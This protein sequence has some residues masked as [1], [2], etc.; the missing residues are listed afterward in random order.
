MTSGQRQAERELTRLVAASGGALDLIG[1]PFFEKSLLVATVGLQIGVIESREDGLDLREREEF[2]LF[3]PPDFPFDR[4]SLC[5]AHARFAGFPHVT[6]THRL[7]LY[8]SSIEWNPSDGLYGF[9]SRL[10]AWIAKAAINDMDPIEGPLEPPHHDTDFT[11][12]PFVVRAD[13]PCAA[14]E[15]WVGLGLT[16]KHENRTELIGWNDLSGGWPQHERVAFAVVL[17]RALP[18]EFP[19]KGAEL[20]RAMQEAGMERE[21][22]VK[23]LAIAALLTPK[24]E[25]IHLVLGLP[26]RRAKD[27]SQRL[28]IAVW[29]TEPDQADSLRNVL[30][31]DADTETIRGLRDKIGDS[32]ARIFELG[33]IKWCQVLEN[34]PEIVVRRDSG[35]PA[36]WFA[37][38]NILVLGCGA[39]G[40]WAAEIMARAGPSDL[41]LVDTA[42]VKPGILARQNF[43]LQDIGSNKAQALAGRLTAIVQG[44]TVAPH[45]REAHA[46]LMEDKGR[47]RDYDLVLDCTA[48]SNFQMKLERDWKEFSGQ[49]PPVVSL[50]IDS[51][52]KHS[53]CVAIPR[54][55][56]GGIWHAY[57]SLK[58]SLCV[59]G[60]H[61]SLIRA[62]YSSSA[63]EKLFQPEPGCSDPTFVGSAADVLALTSDAVNMAV[64]SIQEPEFGVGIALSAPVAS[65]NSRACDLVRLPEFLDTA[66]GKYRVRIATSVF[67][68]ARGW[69][70]QNNRRRSSDHETGGLLW[71][72]WDDA[73]EVIWIYDLSGPPPDSKHSPAHFL[74][75][76]GGTTEEHNRR[77]AGTHGVCGFVGHWHT[78]PDFP[79]EQSATDMRTMAGLVASIGQNQKRSIM[80]I[81]G[82]TLGAATAGIYAYESAS[83]AG[84]GELVSVGIAQIAL[85]KPVL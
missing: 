75:G 50:V 17:P 3:V 78:H 49:T 4:P 5:V 48:S 53:L 55:A 46:F 67:N 35:T 72:F 33:K 83:F 7:C 29:T 58:K 31:E 42:V 65:G 41:H 56:A 70:K 18:M 22:I 79:S 51:Q 37:G 84:N 77:K 14:G 73:I 26:M 12:K 16:V 27:G 10:K 62:F 61:A 6:W 1:E 20:F 23:N 34:R 59:E 80:L 30:P 40:S 63:T 39:L 21:Q 52:A 47:F 25:P 71:G 69:V 85:T 54:G 9:F 60:N 74:C 38:K 68:Q 24:D 13:A 11:Q 19:T 45:A 15:S 66:V 28:H 44:C 81:F 32:L 64:N 8:Q 57:L 76:V 43:L 36:A 2:I 82:R